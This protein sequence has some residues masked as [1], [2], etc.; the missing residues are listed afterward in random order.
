M[1]T[2]SYKNAQMHCAVKSFQS[3]NTC[4][5]HILIYHVVKDQ[6][7]IH[8]I[9]GNIKEHLDATASFTVNLKHDKQNNMLCI[10]TN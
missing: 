6:S 5:L 8:S 7:V 3:W 4:I 2:D 9:K 1:R 10:C